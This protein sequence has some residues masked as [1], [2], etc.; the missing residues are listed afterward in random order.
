MTGGAEPSFP[1]RIEAVILDEFRR[2]AERGVRLHYPLDL[3]LMAFAAGRPPLFQV[4]RMPGRQARFRRA[5]SAACGYRDDAGRQQKHN[6]E[7]CSSHFFAPLSVYVW[8]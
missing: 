8:L 6:K 1:G 5:Q 3:V 4:N 2:M 7:L